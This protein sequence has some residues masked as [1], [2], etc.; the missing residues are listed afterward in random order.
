MTGQPQRARI[1]GA[2]LAG[3]QSTRFGSDKALAVLNGQTLLERAVARLSPW[4]GGVIV[5]GRAAAP[6][7]VPVVPDW[8]RPGMGPLGGVAAALRHGRDAGFAAVL[9]IGVD[10]LGLPD[11]LPE[12]LSP[13]PACLA[14]QPVVGF[15][16]VEAADLA[17]AI[18]AGDGRHSMRALAEAAGAR[19]V[20][21][22][23][24]TINVNFPEDLSGLTG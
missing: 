3:G 4:C 24:P 13:A 14:D 20:G 9:T 23:R 5:V 19:L 8:P 7:S 17:E 12:L 6:V 21:L 18:L 16:P 1:L 11:S 15:W 22:D 10:S 2:V